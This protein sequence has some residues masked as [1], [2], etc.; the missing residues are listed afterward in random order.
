M[1]KLNSS[2]LKK[3]VF[4]M[5]INNCCWLL[6]KYYTF[7]DFFNMLIVVNVAHDFV[8]FAIFSLLS[9]FHL[10]HSNIRDHIYEIHFLRR[11]FIETI[12]AVV[13]FFSIQ[14]WILIC[15]E[16]KCNKIMIF[17][18]CFNDRMQFKQWIQITDITFY[19]IK[20]VLCLWTKKK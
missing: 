9:K 12:V 7:T 16:W 15:F 20:R 19:L 17:V 3:T 4:T 14:Y 10:I 1:N 18:F 5:N 11:L 8:C 6:S 2:N 13:V